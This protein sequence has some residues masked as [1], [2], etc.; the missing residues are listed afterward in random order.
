MRGKIVRE[1]AIGEA[2]GE[3]L[4]HNKDCAR[5]VRLRHTSEWQPDEPVLPLG[6]F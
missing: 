3:L 6:S 1:E 5:K 4:R 2:E